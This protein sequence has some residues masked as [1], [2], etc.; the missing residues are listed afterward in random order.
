VSDSVATA[1]HALVA[2]E[3]R[4]GPANLLRIVT[5]ASELDTLALAFGEGRAHSCAADEDLSAI[6]LLLSTGGTVCFCSCAEQTPSHPHRAMTGLSQ[7]MSRKGDVS[8][9]VAS[10]VLYEHCVP[11]THTCA[12]PGLG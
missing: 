12:K 3:K 5:L 10:T 4:P 11:A 8:T 9:N 7:R 1:R 2:Q 6:R